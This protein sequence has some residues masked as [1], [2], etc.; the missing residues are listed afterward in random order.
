MWV[1]RRGGKLKAKIGAEKLGR[2]EGDEPCLTKKV[3]REW[4]RKQGWWGGKRRKREIRIMSEKE[5]EQGEKHVTYMLALFL[6]CVVYLSC[7]TYANTVWLQD[8]G[9]V[10]EAVHF[11]E[12]SVH[13][14]RTMALDWE[15]LTLIRPLHTRLQIT[16]LHGKRSRSDEANK[17]TS[18]AKSS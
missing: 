12:M 16:P 1:G 13:P 2:G 15:V 9:L 17:T 8:T 6:Y 14:Q 7:K 5:E 18:S 11:L 3:E 4:L 10:S